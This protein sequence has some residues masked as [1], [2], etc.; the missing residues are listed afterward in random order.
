[1]RY[2]HKACKALDAIYD[3]CVEQ[4]QRGL[5]DFSVAH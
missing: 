4:E 5:D 1:M 3:I 2:S